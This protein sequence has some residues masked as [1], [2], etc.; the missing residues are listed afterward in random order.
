MIIILAIKRKKKVSKDEKNKSE[1]RQNENA[2][3]NNYNCSYRGT[4]DID[5]TMASQ[6]LKAIKKRF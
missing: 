1:L 5:R 2:S 4:Y 6:R 3:L